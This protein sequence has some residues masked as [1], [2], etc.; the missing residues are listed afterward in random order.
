MRNLDTHKAVIQ[1]T[2]I[3][4]KRTCLLESRI[5]C[6]SSSSSSKTTDYHSLKRAVL[7]ILG[8]K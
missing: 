2:K 7:Q 4:S 8:S 3:F 5:S 1:T 6:S